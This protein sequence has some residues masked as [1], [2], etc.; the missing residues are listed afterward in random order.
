MFLLNARNKGLSLDLM[1]SQVS[2][3]MNKWKMIKVSKFVCLLFFSI[4]KWK[5][6]GYITDWS[7]EAVNRPLILFD[8]AFFRTT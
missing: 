7:E 4:P 6:S 3:G 8:V 1:H 5:R 2:V